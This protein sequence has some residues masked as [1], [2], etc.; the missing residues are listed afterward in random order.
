MIQ[1]D[2]YSRFKAHYRHDIFLFGVKSKHKFGSILLINL[3]VWGC[4]KTIYFSSNQLV[5]E[6]YIDPRS[7]S[8]ES[9]SY[10]DEMQEFFQIQMF[11]QT[12][13]RN[14]LDYT[15]VGIC[16]IYNIFVTFL[17]YALHLKIIVLFCDHLRLIECKFFK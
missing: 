12:N 1:S 3:R 14:I 9:D 5:S 10:L 13:K 2:Q 11:L 4:S 6:K 16:L 15:T 17:K 7:I 8:L